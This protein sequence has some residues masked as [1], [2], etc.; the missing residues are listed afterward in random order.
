[1][2][3]PALPEQRTSKGAETLVEAHSPQ[4]D[5]TRL[6]IAWGN[7]DRAALDALIP[8]VYR[9]LRAIA[10]NQ[11]RGEPGGHTLQATALVHETYLRLVDQSR[12]RWHDRTHFF[13][14]AARIM[15]RVLVDHARRRL[16]AKRGGGLEA[17]ALD[18]SMGIPNQPVVDPLLVDELLRDLELQD[19][20]LSQVVEMKFFAGMTID[21]IAEVTGVSATTVSR[22]WAVAKAWLGRALSGG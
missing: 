4:T 20:R 2:H 21:E 7:G 6:L 15:R 9:E 5:I 14:V 8:R 1:M 22:D 10:R 16:A 19:P 11:M 12:A 18:P 3:R 13:A 17:I